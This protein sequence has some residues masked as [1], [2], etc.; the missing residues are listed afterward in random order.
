MD[1]SIEEIY[2][3]FGELVASQGV[4]MK[5][6]QSQLQQQNEEL[7]A[8]RTRNEELEAAAKSLDVEAQSGS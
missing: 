4:A 5:R 3:V 8:T 6:M 2:E 1:T 7:T